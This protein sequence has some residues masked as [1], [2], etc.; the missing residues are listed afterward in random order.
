MRIFEQKLE[1][2]NISKSFPGVE[3]L[4]DV[5]ITACSGKIMGL[6]GV[7]GAGKSTLMNI[8]GGIYTNDSGKII[9][10]G[11]QILLKTPN[12]AAKN[13]ISFIHQD[14]LYFASQTVAEN[15]F[16]NDLPKDNNVPFF[17][18]NSKINVQASRVLN[19]LGSDMNPNSLMEELSTGEKQI[20]EIARALAAGSDI[21]IFDEPTSSLSIKEKEKLF[22]VVR[23]LKSENKIIIYISHFL[24]EIQELCDTYVVLRNGTLVG[25]GNIAGETKNNIIRMIIGRDL[26]ASKNQ[27]KKSSSENILNINN[28]IQGDLLRGINFTLNKGEVLGLWGLMGSGRTELVRAVLGLDPIEKG[29]IYF[30]QNGKKNKISPKQLL[31]KCG[32]VTESR[33]VD[34]LFISEPVWKNITSSN[35]VHY[36]KGKLKLIDTNAEMQSAKNHIEKLKIKTP[37]HTTSIENLSGGNQQKTIFSRWLDKRPEI[38]ILDEPT[39][40]VD[41]GAKQEIGKLITELAENG[42]AIL[43]ISSEI[44]ELVS[45]SNRVLVLRDGCVAHE[46]IGEDINE[47]N[48]MSIALGKEQ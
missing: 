27:S 39:R 33:R 35:L 3:A 37:S 11:N 43:L 36:S 15:I 20:I 4:N 28:L 14:L 21:V 48:L 1:M 8:L 26:V 6:V 32:Y 47:V 30:Y 7:N 18:S 40:G 46:A 22:E 10:N 41:V 9:L 16:M 12:D 31:K 25:S 29:E 42:T 23:K 24:N 5:S 19:M 34:G 2:R 38:L 13:G 17:I 44:E 45:L